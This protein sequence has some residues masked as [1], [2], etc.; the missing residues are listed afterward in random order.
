[1]S[2][3][4]DVKIS[5]KIALVTGLFIVLLI[6]TGSVALYGYRSMRA[7]LHT[8]Y[9]DRLLPSVDLGQIRNLMNANIREVL[10]ALQ[11][12]PT[13]P[14]AQQHEMTHDIAKHLDTIKDN[15]QQIEQIWRGYMATKL[16]PEE[17]QLAERFAAAE[18][19]FIERGL[20]ASL[21]LI[22]QRD[23][24]AAALHTV[25]TTLP[26]FREVIDLQ[27]KL[28]EVQQEIAKQEMDHAAQLNEQFITL[29]ITMALLTI[30]GS[31]AVW[32]ISRSITQPLE[33]V[34]VAMRQIA[35][36]HLRI[37]L[38]VQGRDETGQL[39]DAMRTMCARLANVV[40]E[41]RSN[42]EHLLEASQQVSATAQ[43][44]SQAATEQASGVEEVTNLID[45]FNATVQQNTEGAK[46]TERIATAS[47]DKAQQGGQS[48]NEAVTAMQNIAQKIDQIEDIAYKTNL[49][50]LNAAIEAASAGEHGKGFAVVAAEVRRLAELS[51]VTAEEINHLATHGVTIA[52]NA[53][54]Q[55]S[56]VVPDIVETS[57]LIQAI[58]RAS[59]DQSHGIRKINEIMRQLDKVIQQN[60]AASEELAATAE[61]LNAQAEHLRQTVAFF[62]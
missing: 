44:T 3:F 41:I 61:E 29:M 28:L 57:K 46:T 5:Y 12:D 54:S 55:I 38:D 43:S 18:R 17:K 35:S 58:S 13:L 2:G 34:V 62:K 22:E 42:A 47:A 59:L 33:Q 25:Q 8:V 37:D 27:K 60:A 26:A 24:T 40:G 14:V 56:D 20:L 19:Q 9:H 30:C 48:V 39:A 23:F 6:V 45:Q 53:R 1:M 10:L 16:T 36:G 49:L 21:F 15:I 11:H 4:N 52:E 51:R 31:F 7:S 32:G 50:S